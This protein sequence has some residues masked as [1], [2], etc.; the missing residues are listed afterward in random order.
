PPPPPLAPPAPGEGAVSVTATI[1][2]APD[3]AALAARQQAAI[4]KGMAFLV[5]SQAK[6]GSWGDGN[7]GITALC[8]GA[9]VE[10]GQTAADPAV[11][12]AIDF[13]LK[14][15]KD[16]G[17]IYGDAELKNYTTSIA[18]S[19]LVKTDPKTYAEAIEKAKAY[20]VKTQWDEEES[21]DGSNP[22]YGG[23]GYGKQERPD[24]SNTQYF[25]QAMHDAGLPKDHPL[26]AKVV[27]FVSRTQDRS[28]SND[29]AFVGTDSGGM[30]YAPVKEGESKAG[31]V[32][33]PGGRK[34]LKAYGSMTYAGFKSFIYADLQRD[35]P[36]VQAALDWVRKHW[37]FE[38]NPEM[39]QQGLFY[40]YETAAKA[41]KAWGEDNVMDARRRTHDWRAELSEAVLKRQRPDGSWTNEADRWFEGFP[42]VPTSYALIALAQCRSR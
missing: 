7:V 23:A 39:G 40:Y 6:D 18:L 30:V 3:A 37:T 26:W 31:T 16:D 41:L 24:L 27:V 34:G 36:R 28:E 13:M 17:G 11:R 20:L 21:I 9:L 1:E 25:V 5:A 8:A 29:G 22:W 4:E 33:L 38:E 32:D 35:D 15:R 2:V 19:V 10:C 12:R 14:A 42:P